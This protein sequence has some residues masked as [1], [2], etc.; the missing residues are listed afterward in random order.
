MELAAFPSEA[1]AKDISRRVNANHSCRKS[2]DGRDEEACALFEALCLMLLRGLR[3]PLGGSDVVC[4]I[5]NNDL[6]CFFTF[7]V[8]LNIIRHNLCN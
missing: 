1:E 3:G 7:I 5:I 2:G 8:I 6:I 4:L